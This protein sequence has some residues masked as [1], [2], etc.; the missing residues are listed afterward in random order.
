MHKLS[1]EG[2]EFSVTNASAVKTK[3][4]FCSQLGVDV[5]CSRILALRT[6]GLH[7]CR[8]LGAYAVFTK[9]AHAD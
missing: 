1:R 4:D 9:R 2:M 5:S 3:L 6:V 7:S 8:A